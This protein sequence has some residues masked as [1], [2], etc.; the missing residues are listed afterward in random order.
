MYSAKSRA[1]L[2]QLR[3]LNSSLGV[4]LCCD[5]S[6]HR[7]NS[8]LG[9]DDMTLSIGLGNAEAAFLRRRLQ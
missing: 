7:L 5:W 4:A 3:Y 6:D 1:G 8:L 9:V 2:K